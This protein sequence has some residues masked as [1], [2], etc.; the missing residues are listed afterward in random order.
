MVPVYN[1]HVGRSSLG[2]NL[3]L[4]L[5]RRHFALEI[6]LLHERDMNTK[7]QLTKLSCFSKFVLQ[8][9]TTRIAP[10]YNFFHSYVMQ[11]VQKHSIYIAW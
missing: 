9:A 8:L 2:G 10:E 1:S 11:R 6:I 3:L 4:D 5:D 7:L